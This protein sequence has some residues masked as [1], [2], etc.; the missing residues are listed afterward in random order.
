MGDRS[1][2]FFSWNHCIKDLQ[3][4]SNLE[5]LK[6]LKGLNITEHFIECSN[7]WVLCIFNKNPPIISLDGKFFLEDLEFIIATIKENRGE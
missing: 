1:N 5:K 3:I 7:P 4:R 6:D 2:R